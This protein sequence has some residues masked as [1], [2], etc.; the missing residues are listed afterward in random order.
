MDYQTNPAPS[1]CVQRATGLQTSYR[2]NYASSLSFEPSFQLS[3]FGSPWA[4][5]RRDH[6]QALTW[7]SKRF[8][9]IF[10]W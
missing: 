6:I 9:C 5:K 1:R 8:C 10:K 7:T 4:A 2:W 3:S